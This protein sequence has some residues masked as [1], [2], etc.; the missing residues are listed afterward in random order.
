MQI[1]IVCFGIVCRFGGDDL[2]FLTREFRSQLV[3]DGFGDFTFDRK[4]VG[5]FA[6]EC[7]SPQLGIIGRLDQPNIDAHGI[8]ALLHTSFQ[9]MGDAKL[10]CDLGQV[11]RRAFVMLGG[12]ARSDLQ[13]GDLG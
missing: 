6:I 12:C 11:F 4:D 13:I 10:L 2:L 5:Q 7:I 9:D 3:S 1:S 8:A